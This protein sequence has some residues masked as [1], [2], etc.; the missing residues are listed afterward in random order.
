MILK[1][2]NFRD[3]FFRLVRPRPDWVE[4]DL[5][6]QGLERVLRKFEAL[7]LECEELDDL[8]FLLE[9]KE[10]ET[11]ILSESEGKG[12]KGLKTEYPQ[13]AALIELGRCDYVPPQLL[14][15]AALIIVVVE[16]WDTRISQN[17]RQGDDVA[18]FTRRLE[19]VWRQVRLISENGIRHLPA[20]TK[21]IEMFY[22]DLDDRLDA[23]DPREQEA[24]GQD[25]DYLDEIRR[26]FNFYLGGGRVYKRSKKVSDT[27]IHTDAREERLGLTIVDPDS[28]LAPDSDRDTL[29]TCRREE[30]E[31]QKSDHYRSGNSPEELEDGPRTLVTSKP[32]AMDQG[33]SPKQA[34]IRLTYRKAHL[35][36]AAQLLPY[37]WSALSD[38][39]MHRL[40]TALLSENTKISQ[41]ARA[42]LLI[43]VIT[44]RDIEAVGG[45][46]VVRSLE[47]L[48][49][50]IASPSDLYLVSES[51]EWATQVLKPDARRKVK[52]KWLPVLNDHEPSIRL[53]ILEPFWKVLAPM[54]QTR[55]KHSKQKSVKLFPGH[56][57]DSIADEIRTL[58]S[59]LNQPCKGRLTV[60]RIT[61][62]LTHELHIHSGDLTEALLLTGKQPPFGASATIY[63]HHCDRQTLVDQY[64]SV[65]ER[66]VELINSGQPSRP[67]RQRELIDGAV[68]SDLVLRTPVVARFF[69]A[70][71]EQIDHDRELLGTLEGLRHF[72]NSLTNYVLM[73]TFWLS[74]YRA[75]QDPLAQ[76]MEY[77]SARRWLVIN[78]K[79]S[80]GD[81]HSRVV[82]V[83]RALAEQ[84]DLYQAHARWLRN[85]LALAN[86]DARG[87]TFFYLDNDLNES[88]VRP[89]SMREQLEWAYVLPLNLNR[90]WLRG[91]LRR[92]DVPGPY[93]DRFMGHWSI[94]QE[95]WARY[96]S[97]DPVDFQ[98][99]LDSALSGLADLL[100]LA[101]VKGV[102]G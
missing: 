88:Q 8:I 35:R 41:T 81:G 50:S 86:R 62:Q 98:A 82:P 75:V 28:D 58:I 93:V 11:I 47:Q 14:E 52:S 1:G 40:L 16:L 74:G 92:L 67:P 101:V 49:K 89:A 6:V 44:G 5:V 53:P 38:A 54:V 99:V 20:V 13:H 60:A 9:V 21:D 55:A 72:H 46:S 2:L 56:T 17:G 73:M 24:L 78:D 57:V 26:F 43:S 59:A 25:Y 31:V 71:R 4:I 91:E 76:S 18:V 7:G 68:G 33:G 45:A 36:R 30:H 22:N 63:Y 100:G 23:L 37:R 94:G 51:K 48:P 84:L 96:S 34:A 12:I 10:L 27:E 80:D 85:R 65:T 19:A 77:N 79:T 61:H 39:D 83:S 90:H 66:W 87:V 102:V 42:V 95:P 29:K 97:V 64:V 15:L 32:I 3:K 70:L 69:N